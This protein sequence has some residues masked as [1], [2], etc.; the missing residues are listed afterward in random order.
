[1]GTSLIDRGGW[2]E[3]TLKE[4]PD[5]LAREAERVPEAIQAYE[6]LVARWPELAESWF[7]LGVL[8]R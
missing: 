4:T 7:N 6:R 3:V 5:A 1:M 2:L 8:Q